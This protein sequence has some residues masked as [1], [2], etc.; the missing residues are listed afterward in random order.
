MSGHQQSSFMENHQQ[1]SFMEN[2][3][4]WTDLSCWCANKL[5]IQKNEFTKKILI[6]EG[7]LNN[8]NCYF[9][10]DTLE[11]RNRYLWIKMAICFLTVD[12]LIHLIN[13]ITGS[14]N[15]ELRKV[16]VRPTGYHRS[17]M[18][19]CNVE[20]ALYALVD[21]FNDCLITK[22]DFCE[23]FLNDIYLFK[24]ENDKTCKIL[25]V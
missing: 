18:D 2:C 22:K 7:E 25:F 14:N 3:C 11:Y 12:S 5:Q 10:K 17:Y 4:L 8:T 20:F 19:W 15:L 13:L 9:M 23:R 1:S 16:D 21:Y 24:D 6:E